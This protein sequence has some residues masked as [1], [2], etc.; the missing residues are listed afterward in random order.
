MGTRLPTAQLFT[1]AL[2]N[3]LWYLDPHHDTLGNQIACF[4][5][6]TRLK[7]TMTTSERKEATFVLGRPESACASS[8]WFLITGVVCPVQ[9]CGVTWQDRAASWEYEKVRAIPLS[10][11]WTYKSS[12]SF[13]RVGTFTCWKCHIEDHANSEPV[14]C[15]Y[16]DVFKHLQEIPIS[17]YVWMILLPRIDTN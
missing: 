17:Q 14:S 6:L 4:Y 16:T 13:Y 3:A 10:E 2:S 5:P 8:E 15:E 1:K 12:A 7:D 9:V 11:C